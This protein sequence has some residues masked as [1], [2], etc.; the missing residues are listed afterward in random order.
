LRRFFK[1][2]ASVLF[3][4]LLVPNFLAAKPRH[5]TPSSFFPDRLLCEQNPN[6]LSLVSG[7]GKGEW[8]FPLDGPVF[9]AQSEPSGD[10]LVAGGKG[11]VFFLHHTLGKK[12]WISA[13]DW[14]TLDT[15]PPV[16]AVAV[17]WDLNGR[18]TLVLAADPVKKRIFLADAKGEAPK[19]R[20]EFALPAP[21]RGARVCPDSGNFLVTMDT[22]IQEVDFQQAKVIWTLPVELARDAA[23]SPDSDT[24]VVDDRGRVS[25]YDVDQHLLW[26]T[27]LEPSASQW[28]NTTLSLFEVREDIRILVSGSAQ[29]RRGR[30]SQVWVLDSK[31]GKMLA[32]ADAKPND[33]FAA[34]V[35]AAPQIEGT[36]LIKK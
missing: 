14:T 7:Q 12:P 22:L 1:T 6:R 9:D 4:F 24:Y 23:R 15:D 5:S 36:D 30:E 16:S 32:Q 26:Q 28:K 34:I 33:P 18:P 21:P 35:R 17:D 8:T 27:F 13:W 2:S 20:W 31:N 3:I 10:W 11:K 19:I 29:T 25:A